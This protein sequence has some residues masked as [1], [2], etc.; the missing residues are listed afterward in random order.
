MKIKQRT[1][2][3]MGLWIII[4]LMLESCYYKPFI[5]YRLNNRGFKKFSK[6]EKIAG[7]NYNP[8]RD[9]KVNRYDWDLE[10]FP[11]Q[12]RIS[13]TMDIYFT[14][15][16]LQK[17]FLFDLQKKMKIVSYTCS[18]GSPQIDRQGDFIYLN[19]DKQVPNHKRLKL[20]I[21]YQGKPANVAG[22]GPIQWRKDLQERVW[23]SSTT[24]G[25]G[26]QFIMPCNALLQAESDSSSITVTVDQ[27]LTVV[28]NGQLI[29][30]E[31][32]TE[33]KTKTYK[34]EV[35]NSINTYSL[36]FN[37]G[38]FLK[39]T[40]PYTDI[41][42]IERQLI[43]HV[44]DYN[45]DVANKFYDQ[46][47]ILLKEL[48]QLYGEFPFWKDGCKFIEST[49]SAMEHQSAIAMGSDYQND[50]KEFN[51]TLIH[52]LSHEWWG[53]SLTGKDY[54]DI[55][56]H[57]GMATYS[58]ALILER[59]YGTKAYD[60]KMKYATRYVSN[61]IPILKEC[62]VLYNSWVNDRDQ[63]IYDKGALMMHSLRTVV[64]D[65]SLF[66]N[67][68]FIIQRD[69]RTTNI[70][71]DAL[72]SKFN[73]LLKSDYTLLFD[74][75]LKKEK[76]PVLEVFVDEQNKKISYKWKNKIPFFVDGSVFVNISGES[77]PIYP[78]TKY[79]SL[80][81]GKSSHPEFLISKSIYYLLEIKNK[82]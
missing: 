45:Y 66:F 22:Q 9:Y 71:T 7:D 67:S 69:L 38:R 44:L 61:T 57:E 24:E 52:E 20:S 40:K 76:P 39:I 12:Q 37:V 21:T 35:T 31:S 58:E 49:F 32:N 27:D 50:W 55:W 75:Y 2:I 72:I 79:Q 23:I 13:S 1:L 80:E 54:C 3:L 70:S 63:D 15:Q 47:A 78:S 34:H 8:A 60:L 77:K 53:N 59:I 41:N 68:L 65:D 5:G 6:T 48:E 33:A 29:G 11:D 18:E 17:V 26:P 30:V 74:W 42:G 46:T 14:T 64:N 28:S 82:R 16:S 19:F 36:S 56:I 4:S 62:N 43:F 51:T 73:K 81:M 25:I 10:L